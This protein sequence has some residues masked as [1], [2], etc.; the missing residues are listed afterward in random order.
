MAFS[1]PD[2]LHT[3]ARPLNFFSTA[4][5]LSMRFL[6]PHG[7]EFRLRPHPAF[8]GGI[9]RASWGLHA[10]PA[11]VWIQQYPLELAFQV[12]FPVI[13]GLSEFASEH[14]FDPSS[15]RFLHCWSRLFPLTVP[16]SDHRPISISSVETLRR[17]L[18]CALPL[19]AIWTQQHPLFPGGLIR[20]TASGVFPAFAGWP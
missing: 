3:S 18:V 17:A 7:S 13:D 19:L 8:S 11:D 6:S 10:T 1:F 20:P 2:R 16:G 9:P 5:H 4:P 14:R 12:R 15:R